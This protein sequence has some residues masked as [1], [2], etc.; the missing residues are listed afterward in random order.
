MA[1]DKTETEKVVR[2]A[3]CADMCKYSCPTYLAMGRETLSPQKMARLIV[4]NEKGFLEDEKAFL[5]LMFQSAMCGACSSHCIY[6]DYDLRKF[7]HEVRVKAFSKGLIPEDVRKR[8][9]QYKEFG[10]PDGEREI[11]DKGAGN[12]G[13]FVS[14]SSYKDKNL[15]GATEKLFSKSGLDVRCFGGGDICCG[16]PLY[17]AGDMEGFRQASLRMKAEIE[18]K[19]VD[20]IVVDCPTCIKMMTEIY[21]EIGVVLDVE[22]MHSTQFIEELLKQGRLGFSKENRTVTFH[23]PCI[24]SYDLAI[25]DVPR[26]VIKAM[27]FN[28]KEPVYS[29]EQTHCCGS[30]YGAKIGDHRLKDA[31]T[32]MRVNELRNTAADIYVTACPTCK[33]VLSEINMKYITELVAERI[34]AKR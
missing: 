23:D 6:N 20:R 12:L 24:L 16:A 4:Y 7:I 3:M 13:Y 1:K 30:A 29:G 15:L 11:I 17:Y 18:T 10:N 22:I 32:S 5:E 19:Q 21:R 33:S 25:T 34:I 26:D 9:E 2:C 28:L 8:V 31:V 14:C 27:G